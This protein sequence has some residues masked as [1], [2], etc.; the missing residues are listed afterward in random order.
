MPLHLLLSVYAAPQQLIQW[1]AQASACQAPQIKRHAEIHPGCLPCNFGPI[2][3]AKN[4]GPKY[5]S[6]LHMS[7]VHHTVTTNNFPKVMSC[8]NLAT[9]RL[10]WVQSDFR[11]INVAFQEKGHDLPLVC[12]WSLLKQL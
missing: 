8:N 10:I 3:P 9:S 12:V 2:S 7:E 11:T 5:V 1:A 6:L 4:D